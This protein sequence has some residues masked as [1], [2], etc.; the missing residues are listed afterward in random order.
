MQRNTQSFFLM[1]L[2]AAFI[3]ST[4]CQT[5]TTPPVVAPSSY[6]VS[7]LTANTSG[8]GATNLDTNMQD[9]WGL[10]FNAAR[11]YPWVANRAS[12]T[13]TIYDSLGVPKTTVYK[14]N[15][16][17]GAKG[18]PT[19]IV[20]NTEPGSFAVQNAGTNA[21]WI[22]S[23]L[24]GVLAAIAAGSS[25]DSTYVVADRSSSSSF[26]GLALVT[27]NAG[28]ML[29]APNIK[30]GSLD[31]FDQ[32]FNRIKQISDPYPGYTPF[33]AVLIDTQMFVTHAKMSGGFVGV[34]AGNGGYVDIYDMNGNYEKNLISSDSLDEPWGV[35]IAPSTF[36]SNSG[37]LLVANFGDGRINVYDR[38]TGARVGYLNDASGTPIVIPGLW[39]LVV[40]N[41]S[42]YYTSGPNLGK[43]GE[44]GKITA[45]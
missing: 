35:A 18:S 15:G 42:L 24:N 19:G 30:N 22:F 45:R 8:Y 14:V 38:S 39:A 11:G 23:E 28:P 26:T 25:V 16:P 21:T 41:G 17:G 33:N 7:V 34:G 40:F 31:Q 1:G 10:A 3:V 5:S 43:D 6:V 9:A 13:T 2:L 20:I 12:G 29:Y 27:G 36:G 4:G 37:K 32:N 44:F